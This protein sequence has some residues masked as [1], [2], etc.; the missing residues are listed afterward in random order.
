MKAY[1]ANT[2]KQYFELLLPLCVMI[3]LG[4][5]QLAALNTSL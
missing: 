2:Y 3:H 5:R 4:G 1:Q